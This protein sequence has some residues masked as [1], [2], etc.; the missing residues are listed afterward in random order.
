MAR[1]KICLISYGHPKSPYLAGG[2]ALRNHIFAQKLA[3]KFDVEFVFGNFPGAWNT[4]ADYKPRPLGVEHGLF[5]SLFSFS[6]LLPFFTL[7]G[8]WD[9]VIEDWSPYYL[10]LAPLKHRAVVQF[11]IWLGYHAL[12]RFPPPFNFLAFL[13][14]T[15]YPRTFE[16]AVFMSPNLPELW[17]WRKNFEV[18]W[19][20]FP[21]DY[22]KAK[23]RDDGF[24]LFLGRISI[25]MKGLD[26]LVKALKI[27]H[28]PC[29]IA[30][31]GQDR[32]KFLKMAE[33]IDNIKWVGWV[34]GDKKLKLLSSCSFVVLPSRYEG[35]GLSVL[36]G[37]AF[38]KPSV[39][40]RLP[41][42]TWAKDFSVQFE[43]ENPHSL[44]QAI[45]KL[46]KDKNLRYELGRKARNFA[47]RYTWDKVSEDF[48]KFVSSFFE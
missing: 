13:N 16:W 19:S 30:G 33:G 40:P 47:K 45:Q 35:F 17:G 27:A 1:P 21:S 38:G 29:I 37:F 25:Y 44:A 24:A 34:D 23:T 39:V 36:E 18:V 14:Q 32:E 48:L 15:L 10:S 43:P 46:W 7:S 12:K 9:L 8:K 5:P 42:F 20:G 31:D 4:K 11:Q 2:G 22:L 6:L 3:Q 26:L 41:V 28:V